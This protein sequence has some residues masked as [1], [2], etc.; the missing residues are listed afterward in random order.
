[1]K[2]FNIVA[3]II[4]IAAAIFSFVQAVR[5][6][7]FK[8]KIEDYYEKVKNLII[9]NANS[10]DVILLHSKA[11]V[12]SNLLRGYCGKEIRMGINYDDDIQSILAFLSFFSEKK[13]VLENYN[14]DLYDN[15]YEDVNERMD[16]EFEEFR[17]HSNYLRT[18]FDKLIAQLADIRKDIDLTLVPKE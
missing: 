15:F 8:I 16:Y 1:M 5:S 9:T 4:S 17:Q 12:I 6:K 11:V 3:S 7:S 14:K 10:K 2:I 18:R 13:G